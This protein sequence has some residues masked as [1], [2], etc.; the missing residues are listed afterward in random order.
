MRLL[1]SGKRARGL[2]GSAADFSFFKQIISSTDEE[3]PHKFFCGGGPLILVTQLSTAEICNF[4][5]SLV[6]GYKK[7]AIIFRLNRY[8][9]L[10][11]N[12]SGYNLVNV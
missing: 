7:I 8:Y 3:G 12:R 11:F 10:N 6:L 1:H 5:I 2:R 9:R 4:L